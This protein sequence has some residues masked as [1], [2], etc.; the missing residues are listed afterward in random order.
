MVAASNNA[1]LVSKQYP[2]RDTLSFK[3]Q[4]D[5][6]AIAATAQSVQKTVFEHG[7]SSFEFASTEEE[8]EELW[9][10]RKYALTSTIQSEEGA[11]VWTTDVW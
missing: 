3:I 8:A 10:N 6:T 4:G 1:G 2:V 5:S 11:R 9:D 7:A